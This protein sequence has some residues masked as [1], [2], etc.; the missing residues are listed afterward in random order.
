M[1]ITQLFGKKND[2]KINWVES[3]WGKPTVRG[4][5]TQDVVTL[6]YEI[7]IYEFYYYLFL[8]QKRKF[9]YHVWNG[10]DT[11]LIQCFI[12]YNGILL[13]TIVLP[14]WRI[15][16]LI[17]HYHRALER[18][19]SMGIRC[20]IESIKAKSISTVTMLGGSTGADDWLLASSSSVVGYPPASATTLPQGS[21]AWV[22]IESVVGSF[23]IWVNYSRSSTDIS[24]TLPSLLTCTNSVHCR[25]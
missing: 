14:Q 25:S 22:T 24:A 20:R 5:H 17:L 9:I 3:L 16:K 15:L 19:R 23:T 1:K 6:C 18:W 7:L 21:T 2:V 10:M 12:I 4:K 8:F 13:H 11:I